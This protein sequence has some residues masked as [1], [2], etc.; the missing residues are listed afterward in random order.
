VEEVRRKL[1]LLPQGTAVAAAASHWLAGWDAVR[2]V[3][4]LGQLESPTTAAR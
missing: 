4:L 3:E 1:A 2:V